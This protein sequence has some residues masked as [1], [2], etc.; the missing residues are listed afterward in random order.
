MLLDT[1]TLAF[2]SLA[3]AGLWEENV[4]LSR[5]GEVDWQ[6]VYRLS[7]E[8]SVVGL[9]AAGGALLYAGYTGTSAWILPAWDLHK[10]SNISLSCALLII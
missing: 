5:Y 3:K 4:E 7:E 10:R 1:S 6:I 2:L 9:A 8:Q